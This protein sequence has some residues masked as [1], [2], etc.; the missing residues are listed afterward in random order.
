[1]E[2]GPESRPSSPDGRMRAS[3]LPGNGGEES[4]VIPRYWYSVVTG[5]D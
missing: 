1:M 4:G 3:I 5:P 2:G